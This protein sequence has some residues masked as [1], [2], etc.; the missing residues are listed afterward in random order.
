LVNIMKIIVTLIA[1]GALGCG[2]MSA[3]HWFGSAVEPPPPTSKIATQMEDAT[4][5]TPLDKWIESV[6]NRNRRAAGWSAFAV[7]LGAIATS[8]GVWFLS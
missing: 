3:W 4:G 6:A 7:V 1:V 5:R 2:L 8:P